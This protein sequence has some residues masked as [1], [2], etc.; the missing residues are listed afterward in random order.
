VAFH[1]YPEVPTSP[2]S[3]GCVRVSYP[4]AVTVYDFAKVGTPVYVY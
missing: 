4:E 2:A 3:H 1:A